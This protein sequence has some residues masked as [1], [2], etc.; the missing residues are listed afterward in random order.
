M[1]DEDP[2]QQ[3]L[4]V[5]NH[6]AAHTCGHHHFGRPVEKIDID[7]PERWS[8]GHVVPAQTEP[9][10]L[11]P[12]VEGDAALAWIDGQL[13]K[14]RIETAI[15]ARLGGMFGGD[16]WRGEGCS[17]DR[18]TVVQACPRKM[19]LPAWEDLVEVRA[20]TLVEDRRFNAGV[21]ALAIA[22]VERQ[23]EP[24]PGSRAFEIIERALLE[25]DQALR[26]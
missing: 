6:E 24:M 1:T 16:D 18:A 26:P 25:Y 23:H 9:L 17:T 21:K 19:D 11:P 12:G 7:R 22:L 4:R 20:Q 3:L 8:L 2:S 13:Y 15:I 10:I 14:G 5:A